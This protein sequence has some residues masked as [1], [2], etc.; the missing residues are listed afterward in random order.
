MEAIDVVTEKAPP[1]HRPSV[2]V[3]DSS[4][5]MASTDDAPAAIAVKLREAQEQSARLRRQVH[6]LEMELLLRG[7][8][9]HASLTGLLSS[10]E[11]RDSFRLSDCT[12]DSAF[13]H[14]DDTE[15][16]AETFAVLGNESFF[17]EKLIDPNELTDD[18]DDDNE[19]DGNGEDGG[20]VQFRTVRERDN[21]E[22]CEQLQRELHA[23]QAAETHARATLAALETQFHR[24]DS[25][26]QQ[27]IQQLEFDYAELQTR[28]A[29]AQQKIDA[30]EAEW[31]H[32]K[33]LQSRGQQSDA[34]SELGDE[35]E[36]LLESG[37][38]AS[39]DRC[40]CV[41]RR[42]AV[43]RLLQCH[44]WG[45]SEAAVGLV[46]LVLLCVFAN[47]SGLPLSISSRN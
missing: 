35:E 38:V 15:P 10:L 44:R 23:V 31:V 1:R 28:E 43:E 19:H 13:F 39:E 18:E 4:S 2:A 41:Q 33:Q 12:S 36:L 45:R 11:L 5:H 6:L 16:E 40:H 8:E 17:V 26:E 47:A 29:A 9:S 24:T 20:S 30:L 7:S 34:K 14:D 25:M 3:T 37:G 22:D 46:A 21:C 42:W 27:R 32:Q